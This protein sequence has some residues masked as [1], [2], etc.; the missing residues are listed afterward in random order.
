MYKGKIYVQNSR[1]MKNTVLREIN[2]VP[3]VG[4]PRYHNTIAFVRSEYFWPGMKKEVA[5]YIALCLE[6]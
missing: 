2:N 6:C 3:Y 1:E 4:H 5:N